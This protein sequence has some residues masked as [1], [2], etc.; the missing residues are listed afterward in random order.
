MESPFVCNHTALT[1][2]QRKQHAELTAA[3][4]SA[5]LGFLELPD[6]YEFEFV[7]DPVSY[8]ALA[9]LTPL[10]HACCPFFDI[11]IRLEREHGKLWWR[12]TGRDGVKLFIRAEF[13]HRFSQ[14]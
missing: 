12:L 2:E 11:S 14:R 5:L 3:L 9:E 7:P 13:A 8:R 10:E 1:L 6:G 4:R